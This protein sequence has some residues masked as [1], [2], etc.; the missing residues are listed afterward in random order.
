MTQ[1]N[2]IVDERK[3]GEINIKE[4][5]ISAMFHSMSAALMSDHR[6]LI[7]KVFFNFK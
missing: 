7:F 3:L 5:K 4:S 6:H 2:R 1:N